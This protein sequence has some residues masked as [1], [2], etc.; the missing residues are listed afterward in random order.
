VPVATG[1][2]VDLAVSQRV[3]QGGQRPPPG[4]GSRE[5]RRVDHLGGRKQ[6]CQATARI[7][8]RFTMGLDEPRGVGP[9]G[10]CGHLLPEHRADCELRSVHCARYTTARVLVHQRFHQRV[11][12]QLS[13]NSQRV[14]VQVEQ[15]TATGDRGREV[16]QICQGQLAFDVF[17][18]RP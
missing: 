7:V 6:M 14:G 8:D 15:P 17:G 4:F 18:Q 1:A 10:R 16:P 2:E 12:T 3:D 5:F 11:R 13:V 9:G